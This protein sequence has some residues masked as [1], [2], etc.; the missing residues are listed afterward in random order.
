MSIIPIALL[1]VA[2]YACCWV[3]SVWWSK[4]SSSS[5]TPGSGVWNIVEICPFVSDRGGRRRRRTVIHPSSWGLLTGLILALPWEISY[6]G[7]WNGI[8][9]HFAR[10]IGQIWFPC[11]TLEVIQWKWKEWEHS[12]VKMAWPWPDSMVFRHIAQVL[13]SFE[14]ETFEIEWSQ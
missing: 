13:C 2:S 4:T 9:F 10:Q 1:S 12:A 11:F 3:I 14:R 6:A 8:S 7:V 5:K